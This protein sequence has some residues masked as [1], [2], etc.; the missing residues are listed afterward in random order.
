MDEWIANRQVQRAT[1]YLDELKTSPEFAKIAT[2][3]TGSAPKNWEYVN[4]PQFAGYKM[5]PYVAEV[6]N[7]YK[8][9]SYG[10]GRVPG[11]STIN[12]FLR[13]AMFGVF[14]GWH[15]L[16]IIN[17]VTITRGVSGVMPH[18]IYR[19]ISTVI[20]AMKEVSGFGDKYM[21]ILSDGG[22]LMY[23][24][25]KEGLVSPESMRDMVLSVTDEL[26]A[27]K[28]HATILKAL[29][30]TPKKVI[31]IGKWWSDHQQ[32]SLWW[33]NDVAMMQRVMELEKHRGMSE[34]EAVARAG[35][36]LPTYQ[37]PQGHKLLNMVTHPDITWFANYHYGL[38]RA[39]AK[40][41]RRAVWSS[42]DIHPRDR[43]EAFDQL[44]M[45]GIVTF[46]IYPM[47]D[48]AIQQMTG[49]KKAHMARFGLSAIPYDLD[50][51][52]GNPNKLLHFF[53][54]QF[55]PAPGT[56]EILQQ[57]AGGEGTDFWTGDP[58]APYYDNGKQQIMDRVDHI[59][60]HSNITTENLTSSPNAV[61]NILRMVGVYI[62]QS[63]EA[64]IR[65]DIK[66]KIEKRRRQ[67]AYFQRKDGND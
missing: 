31:K 14:S 23:L 65:A 30:W 34:S 59:L 3:D 22:P 54:K 64:R 2:S 25:S 66:A 29:G 24:N 28:E 60:K 49:N 42:K 35:E 26:A 27:K 18:G 17:L 56:Y 20:P 9:I 45:A 4:L 19:F 50:K 10:E 62:P 53:V 43:V 7:R 33:F 16:N 57:L 15:D 12:H 48:S 51:S 37:M 21:R 13:T 1:Q 67:Q 39:Y 8:K 6:L 32:T 11:L 52:D 36:T 55:T 58:I 40:M 41:I 63:K 61:D 38:F 46:V 44:A 47:V 5:E